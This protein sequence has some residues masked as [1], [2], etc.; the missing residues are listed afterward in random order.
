LRS[1]TLLVLVLL[2]GC[3]D[4]HDGRPLRPGTKP[5]FVSQSKIP[6]LNAPLPDGWSRVFIGAL[7]RPRLEGYI[8]THKARG[9]EEPLV[10]HWVYDN[11]MRLTGMIGDY[12][13]TAKI[14]QRGR[15]QYLGTFPLDQSL[16]AIF[17]Y[18]EVAPVNFV[19]MPKPAE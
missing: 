17:G 9:E 11:Q 18:E 16:L 8:R 13:K 4:T 19:A 15:T 2:A 12:G 3:L 5:T 14:D 10:L 6:G 7:P 1:W